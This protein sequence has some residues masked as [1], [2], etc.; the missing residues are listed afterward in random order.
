MVLKHWLSPRRY[1]FWLLFGILAYSLAGFFLAPWLLKHFTVKKVSELGRTL[2]VGTVRI[3]PYM[4]DI[5]VDDAELLDTDGSLLA[6]YDEYYWN[7][8]LS[9]LFNW[10]WTFQ[11]IRLIG[12]RVNAERFSMDDNNFGRFLD[13]FP[14][15]ESKDDKAEKGDL[16][17]L[18]IHDL[19][20]IDG[21]V[22]V[23]DHVHDKDFKT[24]LGPITIHVQD[25]NTLPDRS[26]QQ[27]V[28][29][30]TEDGS[31][32]AWN[33]SL[34]VSPLSSEG[35]LTIKGNGLSEVHRY[36]DLM[37][38]FSTSGGG[39]TVVFDYSLRGTA[40]GS[41]E[42]AVENLAAEALDLA[43]RGPA[44]QG[45]IIRI[46][47]VSFESGSLRWPQQTIAFD[48]LRVSGANLNVWLKEDGGI[49]LLD[50]MPAKEDDEP[51]A[52]SPS[53]PW[54]IDLKEL[55]VNETTI[56]LQDRSLQPHV[57]IALTS[58]SL[59]V[60]ELSNRAGAEFPTQLSLELA[61]GGAVQFEGEVKALP[62]F[63]T[64]GELNMQ[65]VQLAVAQPYV[66]RVIRVNIDGGTLAL[67]GTI[68][69]NQAEPAAYTGAL[70]VS[71]F[72]LRDTEQE[73]RLAGW[74]LLNID[75]LEV[76]LANN[77]L[78]ISEVELNRPFG[79]VHIA[80]DQSTNIGDLTIAQSEVVASDDV[81]EPMAIT[82]GG[83][84]IDDASLD[85][86][87]FSLPLPFAASIRS[88]G[89]EI[90]T[91]S[92]VSA[93][94][95]EVSLEGQVNEYGLA[96]IEGSINS[97][98]FVEHTDI[99]MDFR[100]LEMSRLTPYSIQFAGHAIDAGRIDLDLDYKIAKSQMEGENKMVIRELTLGEKVDH[101]DAASLPLGLAV[102]LLTDSE[103]VIEIDLPV[104]GDLDDP[105][106]SYGSIIARA[107][108]NLI[109]KVVTAPFRLLGKLVGM[110]SED[111]GT[112]QF[113][114]GRSDLS[115]PD[116]EKLVKLA[117]AMQ[118]RPGLTLEVTGVYDEVVD[119]AAIKA[120]AVEAL[121]EAREEVVEAA[122]SELSTEVTRRLTETLF[123][124][125]FPQTTLESVQAQ[126][127]RGGG[128]GSEEPAT[129]DALAYVAGLHQQL[130]DHQP[131]SDEDLI[132]LG[133]A[134][135]EAVLAALT[136]GEDE[137]GLR[138]QRAGVTAVEAE[139]E[140][141]V[142]LELK[143]AIE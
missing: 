109:T 88:L 24:E 107:I 68:V 4:L 97:W 74:E 2:S 76:S 62:S 32:I 56:N 141:A 106:F 9:S 33:G 100:N 138:M 104:S 73:Q 65:G 136:G 140:M 135:A 44:D 103:G 91:L 63:A 110:D 71:K 29:I 119:R 1:R 37:V 112:L 58:L 19:H 8:Q 49:N 93:Q 47:K 26:G 10:A 72:D 55:A 90:S 95:A 77:E 121:L 53:E 54:Q 84:V 51:T 81:A 80:E 131:V 120:Q 126:F 139:D 142:P 16:P 98:A 43:L 66:D 89:G 57:E 13:S 3:N 82:V 79:R 70:Y 87:D 20:L 17:R 118:Q 86:S 6:A 15:D 39:L 28:T 143:V 117:S 132:A 92:S 27:Q 102:A 23:A 61:S 124:E 105:E 108:G 25:L 38:P 59:A 12:L 60:T 129:L 31:S 113:V 116:Q 114:A 18:I 127:M 101:P 22:A 115:P 125:T 133:T 14:S 83:I 42:I 5:R 34:Q 69:S 45:E 122:G 75:H 52:A 64:E 85:F 7:F 48:A 137:A 94:P 128:E 130:V 41:I 67:G 134:R 35:R 36:L 50:I 96:R 99:H 78:Q 21:S 46:P 123:A 11:E 30:V 111:F 40:K